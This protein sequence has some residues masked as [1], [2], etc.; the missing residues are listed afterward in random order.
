MIKELLRFLDFTY[1]LKESLYQFVIDGTIKSCL[2]IDKSYGRTYGRTD[3][4]S[5]KF[6]FH[7]SSLLM[8]V[9]GF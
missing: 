6:C 2:I 1:L 9:Y 7:I 4:N 8:R 5:K 3:P